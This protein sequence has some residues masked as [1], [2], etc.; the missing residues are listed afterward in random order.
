M[1]DA[2]QAEALRE[3]E[4]AALGDDPDACEAWALARLEDLALHHAAEAIAEA[5]DRDRPRRDAVREEGGRPGLR[6]PHR[7]LLRGV[8]RLWSLAA[9]GGP[10]RELGSGAAPLLASR[11]HVA[12]GAELAPWLDAVDV[13]AVRPAGGRLALARMVVQLEQAA[14]RLVKK[15]WLEQQGIGQAGSPDEDDVDALLDLRD[16]LEAWGWTEATEPLRPR[17]HR[18]VEHL[19]APGGRGPPLAALL[20]DLARRGL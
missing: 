11:W 12:P 15:V 16:L 14:D 2:H 3:L 18:I 19:R 8:S 7:H 1:S 20:G 4:T 13:V 6:E 17:T 5:L 9:A 10:A